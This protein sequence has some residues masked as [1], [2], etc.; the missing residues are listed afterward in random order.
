[1]YWAVIFFLC[2]VMSL[3]LFGIRIMLAAYNEFE[4][5]PPLDIFQIV[6]E[7]AVL[8]LF[9]FLK[10]I[11][12]Y[13]QSEMQGERGRNINMWL[14]FTCPL[15]GAWPRAQAC[16]LTGNQTS[17]YLAHRPVLNPLNYTS[18]GERF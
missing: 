13:R 10:N 16:D 7:R 9:K 3:S 17:N 8:V 12:F 15:L 1:M 2:N 14:P 6:K 11:Y 18:Q 5:L 4:S